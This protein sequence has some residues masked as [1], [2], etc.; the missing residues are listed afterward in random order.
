MT[1][2]V[3]S[4]VTGPDSRQVLNAS[5]LKYHAADKHDTPPSHFKLTLGQPRSRP[6]MVNTNQGSSR[7]QFFSLWLDPTFHIWSKHSTY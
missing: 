1:V 3:R 7:C 6:L 4:V 2:V 5:T